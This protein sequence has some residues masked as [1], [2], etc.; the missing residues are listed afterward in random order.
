MTKTL[1]I[2]RC[3]DPPIL[4]AGTVAFLRPKRAFTSPQF[5]SI[6]WGAAEWLTR[7]TPTERA[8][9]RYTRVNGANLEPHTTLTPLRRLPT[10]W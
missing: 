2:V 6:F 3:G 10:T 5:S 7:L 1:N 9:P 4:N 8:R